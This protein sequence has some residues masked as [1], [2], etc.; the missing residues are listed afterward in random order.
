MPTKVTYIHV[1][2]LT[3]KENFYYGTENVLL[4]V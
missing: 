1:E 2:L 3:A 4:P